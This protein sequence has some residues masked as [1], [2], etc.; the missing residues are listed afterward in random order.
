MTLFGPQLDR[1]RAYAAQHNLPAHLKHK[2][3]QFYKNLYTVR[4]VFDEQEMFDELPT[5]L[6]R[7]LAVAVL[8]EPFRT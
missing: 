3:L 6:K 7:E 4:T 1:F 8:D 5:T 2:L